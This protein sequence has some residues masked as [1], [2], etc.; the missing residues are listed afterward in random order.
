MKN[1]IN[2][3]KFIFY[4]GLTAT[5]ILKWVALTLDYFKYLFLVSDID[6]QTS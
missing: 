6:G 3:F 2:L 1:I 4:A 5:D